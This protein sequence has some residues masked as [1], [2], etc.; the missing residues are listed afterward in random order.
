MERS[1]EDAEALDAYL[2]ECVAIYN[3]W[4]DARAK[5][6]SFNYEG[7]I[8]KATHLFLEKA[9]DVLW[10]AVQLRKL[11]SPRSSRLVISGIDLSEVPRP[12]HILNVENV[13]G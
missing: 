2:N 3:S 13:E 1:K 8:V 4:M 9:S 6:E 5:G 10:E 11:L 7:E 12:G